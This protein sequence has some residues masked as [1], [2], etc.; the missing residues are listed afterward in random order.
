MTVSNNTTQKKGK[1]GIRTQ[2]KTTKTKQHFFSKIR[3]HGNIFCASACARH[4]SPFC[5][6]LFPVFTFVCLSP[7]LLPYCLLLV[8]TF[9]QTICTFSLPPIWWRP[10]TALS[11]FFFRSFSPIRTS[12]TDTES[13]YR[14]HR[15][16][17]RSRR[18]SRV[19]RATNM[20]IY[21]CVCVCVGV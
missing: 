14:E 3:L 5:S 11:T 10:M 19:G 20:V 12:L 4:A 2:T 21:V 9:L 13:T 18:I 8:L 16:S 1:R 15:P 6:W 17:T 7:L